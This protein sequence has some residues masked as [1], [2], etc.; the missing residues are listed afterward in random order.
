M[1]TMT[2]RGG[3]RYGLRSPCARDGRQHKA[4]PGSTLRFQ[5]G[6]FF[7]FLAFV[8]SSLRLKPC[9]S[10]APSRGADVLGSPTGRERLPLG[11]APARQHSEGEQNIPD[12]PQTVLCKKQEGLL[13]GLRL[14]FEPGLYPEG[15]EDHRQQAASQ[16]GAL[17]GTGIHFRCQGSNPGH[18][19]EG[20]VVWAVVSTPWASVSSS[21][22]GP[23]NSISLKNCGCVCR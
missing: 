17:G 9:A 20:H 23:D 11:R 7:C 21:A 4:A 2:K 19:L 1:I 6:D 3:R 10:A 15:Y 18:P 13:A 12:Q 22:S 14:P 5:N 8:P 16:T